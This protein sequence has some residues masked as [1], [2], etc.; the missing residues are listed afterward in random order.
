M[1]RRDTIIIA[2]L[3]NTGL[4]AVLFMMAIN[5]EN[6]KTIVQPEAIAM[7]VS[8]PVTI[9]PLNIIPQKTEQVEPP[10]M[11][12]EIDEVLR[13]YQPVNQ[14][15]FAAAEARQEHSRPSSD[16]YV[17]VRVKRGDFLDKIARAN[18]TTVEAIMAINRM[19]SEKVDVGQVLLVPVAKKPAES[20]RQRPS[21]TAANS[22][23]EPQYYTIKSG[24]NPWKIAK[25]FHVRF[26]E[27][28]ALNNLDEAK[29]RNLK[30]GDVLRV[31]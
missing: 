16:E 27:L 18:G 6:T 15:S 21:P 22:S 8:E 23:A 10:R 28:L 3:I 9:E 17:Q 5:T 31:R 26:D 29:A 1:N 12:D 11:R 4:L 20:S 13:H 24:D 25:Q 7:Q 19:S 30:P 14:S 2:V